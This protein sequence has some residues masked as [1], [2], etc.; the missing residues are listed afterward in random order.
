MAAL[1]LGLGILAG[2]EI[3]HL[4][5]LQVEGQS[6]A[7]CWPPAGLLLAALI[8]SPYRMWPICLAAACVANLVSDVLIHDKTVQVSLGFCLANCGEACIGAWALRHVIGFQG[9]LARATD[10]LWFAGVTCLLSSTIGASVGAG[11]VTLAYNADYWHSWLTWWSTDAVSVLVVTPVVLACTTK[12][13]F[14]G[15]N[16]RRVVE[17][18]TL[19]AS[20]AILTEAVYGEFLPRP[21]MVPIFVLPF[22]LW[23]AFRFGPAGAATAILVVASIGLWNN[24]HGKGPYAALATEP[25]QAVIRGQATLSVL[26]LVVLSLAALVAE[27]QEAER[28]KNQVIDKL[29]QAL[30]EI[31]T[32][33]GLIPLCAWCKKIRDDAGTWKRLED[34]LL[35]HTDAQLSHGICPDCLKKELTE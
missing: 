21:L 19:F 32:L 31:K 26:S 9:T 20:M 14:T 8:L 23:A 29:E 24:S 13:A 7:T 1:L 28:Q 10:V 18:I 17:A 34:Y 16:G 5:S 33:R 4:L 30:G 22:L 3:G 25:T 6:F 2:A 27:R 11:V 35:A 15:M 12:D